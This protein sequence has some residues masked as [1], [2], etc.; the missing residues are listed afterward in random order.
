MVPSFASNGLQK[1]I[2]RIVRYCLECNLCESKIVLVK[3]GS[4]LKNN[5]R[6]NR[7]GQSLEV[8]YNSVI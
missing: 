4:K 6:W 1:E 3:Y 7:N 8:I 2:Y 5:G